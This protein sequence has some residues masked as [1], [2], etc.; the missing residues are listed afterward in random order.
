[1]ALVA[2]WF[3]HLGAAAGVDGIDAVTPTEELLWVVDVGEPSLRETREIYR[4]ADDRLHILTKSF[5]YLD[6][7]EET[8][9]DAVEDGI[10][11]PRRPTPAS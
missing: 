6:A 2:Q 7:V 4:A 1:V 5:E 10:R 11:T 8:L 3:P 9:A